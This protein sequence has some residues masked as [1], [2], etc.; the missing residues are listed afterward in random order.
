MGPQ[1]AGGVRGLDAIQ[2][3]QLEAGGGASDEMHT[4][5]VLSEDA[6]QQGY[7]RLVGRAVHGWRGDADAQFGARLTRQSGPGGSG[8][9]AHDEVQAVGPH[10]EVRRQAHGRS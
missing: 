6:S 4:T 1:P 8:D 10:L 2:S 7:D 5:A 3:E 9:H